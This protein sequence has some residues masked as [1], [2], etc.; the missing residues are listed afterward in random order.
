MLELSAQKISKYE[1]TVS[2]NFYSLIDFDG[3]AEQAEFCVSLKAKYRELIKQI[4]NLAPFDTYKWIANRLESRLTSISP[5]DWKFIENENVTS[6]T[7]YLMHLEADTTMLEIVLSALPL[8][9]TLEDSIKPSMLQSTSL[10]LDKTNQF[11]TQDPFLIRQKISILTALVKYNVS[12]IVP[13][14]EKLFEYVTFIQKD[15]TQLKLSMPTIIVRKKAVDCLTRMATSIPDVLLEYYQIF[16]KSISNLAS[17]NTSRTELILLNE[18]LVSIIFYSLKPSLQDK[19]AS[20]EEIVGNAVLLWENFNV[21]VCGVGM[22]EFLD[23]K[24]F[25]DNCI[26]Y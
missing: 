8:L 26:Y 14:L 2:N 24:F 19:K 4:T 16:V 1:A 25:N 6:E 9:N 15:D 11:S 7:P 13:C 21:P 20:F 23:L 17:L 3:K 12:L 18:F 10:L 22:I 5:D